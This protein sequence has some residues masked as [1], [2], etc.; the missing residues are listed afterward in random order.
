MILT[1]PNMLTLLRILLIPVF[2]GVFYVPAPWANTACAALLALA[3]ITDWLD[4]YLARRMRQTSRFGAFLDPVADKLMVAAV[5]VLLV[6]A[7]PRAVVAVPATIIIGRE[8]A[9]SGL[10][11]FMAAVGQRA[12]V[13]VVMMG[14]VK[15]VA[16]FVALLMMVYRAD[17]GPVPVYEVGFW[18]LYVAAVLTLW[19][20]VVYLRAAWPIMAPKSGE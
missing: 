5:L 19:S 6:Q 16:Q 12:R 20:M 7:D 2:V 3:G 9:V 4:G 10:R 14:K 15:T 1:I 17:I 8:I 18:L 11:E 13:A